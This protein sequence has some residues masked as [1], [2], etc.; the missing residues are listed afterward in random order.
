MN[1]NE[2]PYQ[3]QIGEEINRKLKNDLKNT[4]I[5]KQIENFLIPEK[6]LNDIQKDKSEINEFEAPVI[7]NYNDNFYNPSLKIKIN[8][9]DIEK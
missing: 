9:K 7:K 4:I 1:E 6:I 5:F 8:K 2:L 3:H